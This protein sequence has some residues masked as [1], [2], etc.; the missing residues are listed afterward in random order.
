VLQ[1]EKHHQS[2]LASTILTDEFKFSIV[3]IGDL[4]F[5]RRLV[6]VDEVASVAIHASQA[7]FEV[8]ALLGLVLHIYLVV[9]E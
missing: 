2:R 8:V 5:G 7:V 9:S 1:A 3:F 6:G 4:V